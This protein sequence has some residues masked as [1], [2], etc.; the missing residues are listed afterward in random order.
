MAAG[1]PRPS[2]EPPRLNVSFLASAWKYQAGTLAPEPLQ[3]D[4]VAVTFTDPF[5]NASSRRFTDGNAIPASDGRGWRGHG[6]V[7]HL[8]A[9]TIFCVEKH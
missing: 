8:D 6:R 4:N 5:L 1:R 9:L 3:Q 7:C 2:A